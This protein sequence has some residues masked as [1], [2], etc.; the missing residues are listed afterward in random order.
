MA[1]I[2]GSINN[3][4]L[5]NGTTG[6]DS[7]ITSLGHDY[8][9][10]TQGNDS[11]NLGYAKSASYWK[12][13]FRDFDSVDYGNAWN[14]YGFASDT[15]L[16]IVAD[17]QLGTVKKLTAAG[18]LLS[19]DKLIG[20]DGVWGTGGADKFYGR[21]FWDFEQ[22][23]ASR[24]GDFFDG[25]GGSDGV[26]Y[27]YI[28]STAGI[29]VELAAGK[30]TW[31]DG[32]SVDT[33]RQI[34]LIRGTNFA[35]TYDARGFSDSSTNKNSAGETWNLF[36]PRGGDDK[37]LGNGR[38]ILNS[39][40]LGGAVSIDLSLQ[41]SPTKSA[42]IIT[43][44][45]D[46]PD[47][48]AGYTPGKI[49][50]SG[51]NEVRSGSYDDTLR[52]GGRVNTDGPSAASSV[53]GDLSYESF[54]GNGGNDRIDGR[55]GFDR[56]EYNVGDQTQGIVVKLAAGTVV[57]DPLATGSDTLRGIESINSTFMDD[58]YDAR[59][60]TLSSAAAPSTNRGD[61]KYLTLGE[62]LAS[63]A[64][65]EFRAYGGHD[66]V[67]GNDAT[68]VSFSSI[69]VETLTG[70]QPS[71]IA[72]FSSANAGSA[73]FGNTDGG[74]GSVNF[75]GTRSIIGS[76]GNDKITGA[77]GHQA[78]RGYY[79]N[80]TLLGGDGSD[81][82]YGHNGGSATAINLSAVYSDNDRLDGGAGNDLL[83]GD[84][85]NDS[86]I[87]GTGND[88]L[89][90]G[91]GNDTLNGGAGNDTLSGG[92]GNDSLIGGSGKDNFRFDAALSA[93][94]NRDKISDFVVADDTIQL[95]NAVFTKLTTTGTL[96]AGR[97]HI[98][99]AAQDSND[100]LIYNRG[101]GA[102]FYDADGNGSASAQ[103]QFATLA[104]GLALT[105]SDFFVT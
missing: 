104:T 65:N 25:R 58:V 75:T 42:Y 15:A 28:A 40:E 77:A 78:L 71:V 57:G 9:Q 91:T 17:L 44:F 69:F 33:L 35:D 45:T 11:Y 10:A 101:T 92:A 30:V 46:N 64:F 89:E 93:T 48:T 34:E 59:G 4:N 94:T 67:I 55:T 51:V 12:I 95:E 74:Y 73:S 38:T 98:G 61:V 97:L 72:T 13:T 54:R 36:D 7:F 18:T 68:R 76:A 3:D 56:A 85:G 14:S 63:D 2:L 82:L 6:N 20:V 103:V 81:V 79:G 32:P 83:R 87:G 102:L 16:K 84:F 1:T 29:K 47:S 22:F 60:F 90:G 8:V 86:L 5:Y 41:T 105:A 43:S 99:S 52:G 66:T 21:D 19:T 24:G 49:L 62:T 88:T 50:A 39:G 26:I 27:Q 70:A 31:L 100:F 53:S 80:D 23:Y 96:A 37:V